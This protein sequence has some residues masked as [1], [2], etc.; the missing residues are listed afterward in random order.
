MRIFKILYYTFLCLFVI[1]CS[2]TIAIYDEIPED[3]SV[4][5]PPISGF[6]KK[7]VLIEDY[8]GTWCGNCARVAY[9]IDL[10][11]DQNIN[12]VAVGIHN[13]NDPFNFLGIAPLKNLI[14]PNSALQL[15]QSRLNRNI[16]WKFPEVDNLNQVKNLTGNNCPL[17]LAIKSVVENGNINL[18]VKVKFAKNYSNI[19]LVVYLLEDNLIYKQENYSNF[20][21]AINPVP[22]FNHKHVLRASL[23]NI[24]GESL[25]GTTFGK[26][27]TTNFSVPVPTNVSNVENLN[28][29]A[30]VTDSENNVI[31]VRATNSKNENQTF[32]EN[33]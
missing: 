15:P 9:A 14:S 1:S 6:F 25:I 22:N 17:G 2:D 27:L 26:V 16:V 7:R 5:A 3:S 30:F 33:L 4:D 28:F 20:F 31:N 11:K 13:G 21:G 18:D 12:A 29:V 8:T 10:V 23:G 32:E 24:M 19:K